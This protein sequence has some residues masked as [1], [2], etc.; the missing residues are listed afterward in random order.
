MPVH[1]CVGP[2]RYHVRV[3]QDLTDDRGVRLAGRCD[4]HTHTIWVHA[5]VKRHA[6]LNVALHELRHA[7][8]YHFP[9]PKSEEEECDLAASIIAA[10]FADLSR[11][12]GPAVIADLE[13]VEEMS[14]GGSGLVA[15]LVP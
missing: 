14:G 7:W 3:S 4:F 5:D 15:Y 12:G 2:W 9:K 10:A 11:M 1:F 8:A 6:R 13:P